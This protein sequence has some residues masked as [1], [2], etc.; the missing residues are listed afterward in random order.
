MAQLTPYLTYGGNMLMASDR[1]AGIP[2][3]KNR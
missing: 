3:P 2:T 1:P